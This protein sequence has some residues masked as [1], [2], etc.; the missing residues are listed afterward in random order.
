MKA[1]VRIDC[2]A[3]IDS[4]LHYPRP[5]GIPHAFAELELQFMRLQIIDRNGRRLGPARAPMIKSE[6]YA[7]SCQ[8]ADID[9]VRR[10]G[11]STRQHR[12]A[13]A[14][15]IRWKSHFHPHG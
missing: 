15:P 4:H 9:T 3:L 6:A 5:S 11:P 12:F 7:P 13:N 1:R 14:D 10:A 2:R 8:V